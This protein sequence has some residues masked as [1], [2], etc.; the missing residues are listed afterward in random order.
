MI[1]LKSKIQ[2]N[3][4]LIVGKT[5]QNKCKLNQEVRFIGMRGTNC[6]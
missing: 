1:V 3:V 4:D 6:T 2:T 5:K